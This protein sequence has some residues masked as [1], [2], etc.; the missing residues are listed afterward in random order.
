MTMYRNLLEYYQQ[1]KTIGLIGFL[2]FLPV[3]IAFAQICLSL[4]ALSYLLE[5]VLT[6][7]VRWPHTPVNRPLL[8]YV[9]L[10]LVTT[11][12]AYDPCRSVHG[13]ESVLTIS[14]FYLIYLSIR[15][16][17]HL[18]K[19]L[20]LVFIAFTF[21][22]S[23]GILQH[24]LEV[25]LF[26]LTKPINLLK[27][28]NDDLKAPVRISGFSS[29]MTFSGQLAMVIPL[30]YAS[31]AIAHSHLKRVLLSV[32]LGLSG[33]ALLWTYTRSG[34]LAMFCALLPFGYVKNKKMTIL[35]IT[36]FA[37]LLVSLLVLEQYDII[38]FETKL[39]ER[40]LSMFHAKE[41]LERI[42]TW[43]NSLDIIKDYPFTGIGKGN[44]S[45]LVDQYRVSYG[46]FKF[47]SRAHAH[48]NI[49][50]VT[51][52]G[53]IPTLACFLW[54]WVVM[55]QTVYHAYQRAQTGN[56]TIKIL[57]LGCLGALIA[58]FIQGGF[59]YNFGDSEAVMLMWTILAFGMKLH[60]MV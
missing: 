45:K 51:V 37:I 10:L 6:H 7:R 41:N 13:L 47:T 34:W 59:E 49:L 25:D 52:E 9:G 27:H 22:A 24:Y 44:F 15:D 5:M 43:Q 26:R 42:Y 11:L 3:S 1:L 30:L 58:F 23:Y 46:D 33:L 14:V 32:S 39:G 56:R 38:V 35:L 16:L 48:N 12:C 53:G 2:V 17:E 4:L 54:L 18:K 31:L 55:F 36:V 29:Y 20:A 57:A 50:Q 8:C 60:E 21:A 19:L 28:V 40:L